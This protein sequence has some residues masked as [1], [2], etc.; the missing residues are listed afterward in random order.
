[1]SINEDEDTCFVQTSV[2]T[3]IFKINENSTVSDVLKMFKDIPNE[4]YVNILHLHDSDV[5]LNNNYKLR[6][7]DYYILESCAKSTSSIDD[8]ELELK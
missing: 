5:I 3:E 7:N 6:K 2:T 4:F 8:T 1:M